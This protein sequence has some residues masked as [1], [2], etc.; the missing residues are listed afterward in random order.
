[1]HINRGDLY[2]LLTRRFKFADKEDAIDAVQSAVAATWEVAILREPPRNPQAYST[3][4][5]YRVMGRMIEQRRRFR[6]PRMDLRMG[7][8]DPDYLE[9]PLLT[10]DESETAYDAHAVLEALPL[11]HADVLRR[12]Y[13]EG[14]PLEELA[15]TDGVSP[16]CMRKRHERAIKYARKLFVTREEG[17]VTSD[18]G[19]VTS[20]K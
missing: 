12:H 11:N 19:R 20:D 18:E 10:T 7:V 1:M 5:A 4:V 9:G 17:G 15:R 3:V 16:E 14:K 2:R 8:V 6:R 13:L